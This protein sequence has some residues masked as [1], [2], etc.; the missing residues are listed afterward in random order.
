MLSKAEK[1]FIAVDI[2]VIVFVWRPQLVMSA[3]SEMCSA[4]LAHAIAGAL[5]QCLKLLAW[6]VGDR[7]FEL[8]SG[9]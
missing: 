6:K 8:C 3:Q 9:I 1:G 4:L 2:S 5:V 7:V